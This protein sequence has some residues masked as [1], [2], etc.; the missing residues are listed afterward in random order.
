MSKFEDIIPLR[1]LSVHN[2]ISHRSFSEYNNLLIFRAEI[3]EKERLILSTLNWDIFF[4]TSYDFIK[5]YIFD[6]V[7]NNKDIIKNLKMEN[8]VSNLENIAIYLGKLGLH[9]EE[10]VSYE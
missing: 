9:I 8:T 10:F 3:R 2:K 6:F 1:I 7:H 4:V 5:T